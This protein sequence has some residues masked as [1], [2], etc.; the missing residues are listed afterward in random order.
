MAAGPGSTSWPST[1]APST[2]SPSPGT[3]HDR[4]LEYVGHLHE[5]FRDPVTVRHGRFRL[6]ER[7]GF[8]SALRPEAIEMYRF[9][10]GTAWREQ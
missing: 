7:P 3:L 5:H 4:V 10:E 2:T 9:P 6:P 8:S 1:S